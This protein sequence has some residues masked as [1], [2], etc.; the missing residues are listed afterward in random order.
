MPSVMY[1]ILLAL[2]MTLCVETCC[3]TTDITHG[4]CVD[5]TVSI[6]LR[7]HIGVQRHCTHLDRAATGIARNI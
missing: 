6:L 5:G 7:T 3:Q 4:S 1:F 2:T